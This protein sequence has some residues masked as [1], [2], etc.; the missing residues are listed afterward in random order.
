MS[1]EQPRISLSEGR[2]GGGVP[3]HDQGNWL[4]RCNC[5]CPKVTHRIGAGAAS[6]RCTPLGGDQKPTVLAL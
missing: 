4:G 2:W 3:L 1:V 6:T 5:S